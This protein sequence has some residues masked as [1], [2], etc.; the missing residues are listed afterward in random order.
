MGLGY[1]CTYL[2]PVIRLSGLEPNLTQFNKKGIVIN[3]FN[4]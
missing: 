3:C 4:I 2:I 1:L